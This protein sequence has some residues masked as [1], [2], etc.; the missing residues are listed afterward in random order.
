MARRSSGRTRADRALE[1][2]QHSAWNL[3]D[4]TV[5][6][7]LLTGEHPGELDT[8]FGEAAHA[9]LANLARQ[10]AAQRRRGGP[11]VLILP[12]LFGSRLGRRIAPADDEPLG[13]AYHD[14]TWL[15][16]DGF[17]QGALHELAL[18]HRQSAPVEPLGVFLPAYLKLKLS[19]TIAG[20]DPEFFPYD[21]RLDI[22]TLGH[23]LQRYLEKLRPVTGGNVSL[24][25]H[26]M[27]GLVA[28]AALHSTAGPRIQ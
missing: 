10:A 24:V 3:T 18:S 16:P 20:Y 13:P 6:T 8:L 9:E 25:A 4:E 27:G 11:K 2:S 1:K 26:G 15:D 17:A 28:R 14:I 19:L 21:W 5:E 22:R 12:D 23:Q 7:A